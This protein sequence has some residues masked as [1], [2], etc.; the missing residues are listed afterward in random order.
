MAKL[1]RKRCDREAGQSTPSPGKPSQTTP[2]HAASWQGESQLKVSAVCP[3]K[4]PIVDS[5]Y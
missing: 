2:S 1:W 5:S 3:L 4:L